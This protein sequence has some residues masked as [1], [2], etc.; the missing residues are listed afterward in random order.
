MGVVNVTP[1]SFSDGGATLRREE[2][3]AAARAAWRDGAQIV[4][5]GGASSRPG[6][7]P[8]DPH[9][10]AERVV[11]VLRD[12]KREEPAARLSVDTTSAFVAEAALAAGADLVNDTGG[13][14]DET[15]RALVAEAGVPAVVMHRKGEPRTMQVDPRYGDVVAEVVAWL[16]DAALRAEA[17]GVSSLILD[18]GWGF[19]KRAEHNRALLLATP[20]IV[21]L[22]RP[23]MVGASRKATLGEVT[24]ERVPARRDAASVAVHVEAARLGAAI[25][26]A[27]DVRSHVHAMAVRRWLDG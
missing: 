10:E 6:A 16:R 18:P 3:V 22:G 21:A 17:A 15:L 9:V 1:D 12:L 2:A 27:H 19:G 7:E 5:V 4:D 8:V 14:S 24:G 23:V 13:L 20:Q 25:V 26:R 11:S